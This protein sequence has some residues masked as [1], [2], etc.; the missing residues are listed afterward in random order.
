MK[1]QILTF[2]LIIGV[3]TFSVA[4]IGGT[5]V[6]EFLNLSQSAR[7]TGLGGTHITVM[8]EDLA[9]AYSNPAALNP[10]MNQRM[11]FNTEFYFSGIIQGYAGY[12]QY[13]DKID[14][15]FH[16]G[17][18]YISYGKFDARDIYANDL[19]QFKSSEY[20]IVLGS[21]KKLNEKLSAGANL[22]IITSQLEG[23]SSFGLA[24]D[25]AGMYVDTAKNF[26][27]SLV[28]K[29]MGG[30][31]TSY[32]NEKEAIPFEIQAGFSKKLKYLPFRLS[33]MGIHLQKW[34]ILYD[35]PN[36][37]DE[38]LLFGE[39]PKEQSKAQLFVDNFF[40]H[41][42]FNGEFLFG[43]KENFQL[44]LGYNHLRRKELSLENLRSLAGFS[45]G[46]G[47]KIKNFKFDYGLGFYFT[48]VTTHH[49][50]LLLNLNEFKKSSQ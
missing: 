38:T 22:K 42:V 3:Y 7:I 49:L 4:Q 13:S 10:L 48:G 30:Q 1:T 34:N 15:S 39:A 28:F 5:H 26:T 33:V 9:L 12:S 21:S 14:M 20:A 35:D 44:R 2:L 50:G 32:H 37:E 41:L 8:D 25:I 6:Y 24:M 16:G 36:Q 17:I 23:F 43:K 47:F 31:I 46:T 11:T 45:A 27:A 40:R 18:K 19:G 29:N